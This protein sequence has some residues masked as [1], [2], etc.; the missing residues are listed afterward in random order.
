MLADETINYIQQ[1]KSVTPD[2]PFFSYY[3]PG[4]THAARGSTSSR[5]SSASR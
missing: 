4:A 3:A 5:G 2:R 1:E